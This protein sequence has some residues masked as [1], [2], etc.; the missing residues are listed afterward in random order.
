M[1]TIIEEIAE[2]RRDQLI[3]GREPTEITLSAGQHQ[4]LKEWAD[5]QVVVMRAPDGSERVS[6]GWQYE[7][8]KIFGMCF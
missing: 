6:N 2:Y 7:C 5:S 3:L 1:K 4:G 8:G